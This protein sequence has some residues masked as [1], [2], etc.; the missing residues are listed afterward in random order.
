MIL[1]KRDVKHQRVKKPNA[2]R[3]NVGL[4][5][6]TRLCQRLERNKEKQLTLHTTTVLARRME[7]VVPRNARVLGVRLQNV[8]R[9][10]ALLRGSLVNSRENANSINQPNLIIGLE[11]TF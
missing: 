3:K 6:N 9:L 8:V 1:A 10:F 5:R 2:G 11:K 7:K 4:A